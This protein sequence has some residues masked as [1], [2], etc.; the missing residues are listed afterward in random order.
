MGGAW[1]ECLPRISIQLPAMDHGLLRPPF[2]CPLSHSA[3]PS[4]SACPT[5]LHTHPVNSKIVL[6][7]LTRSIV[8][9]SPLHIPLNLTRSHPS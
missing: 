3:S 1:P 2:V 8:W 9:A 5:Y 7:P 6:H 4:A